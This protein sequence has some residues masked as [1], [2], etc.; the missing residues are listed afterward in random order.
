MPEQ[1]SKQQASGLVI[2]P[3]GLVVLSLF[4]TDPSG[5]MSSIM[6]SMGEMG[7]K[8]KMESSLSDVKIL[9][10]DGK[11][12]PAQIVLRDKDLDLAY[13]RPTEKPAQP[14]PF[15]DLNAT[16]ALE[17]LDQFVALRRLGKVAQR[18]CSVELNRIQATVRKP[19]LLY[20]PTGGLQGGLEPGAAVFT[21][22]GKFVGIVVLRMISGEGGGGLFSMMGSMDE[23]MMP[24]VIPA[25][26]ILEGAKQAP[27][28]APKEEKP[29]PAAP[30]AP[31]APAPSPQ[32]TPAPVPAPQPGAPAAGGGS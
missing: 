15:V 9:L 5:L 21:L 6:S 12:L 18:A 27:Q 13:V 20:V 31:E 8:F 4:A 19:R 28:E 10:E 17:V 16:G 22:D 29:E 24:V 14:L 30:A 23:N 25:A 32:E 1:E 7:D 11:E 3:S 26:D 2:D